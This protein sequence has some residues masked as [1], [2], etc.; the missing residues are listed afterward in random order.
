MLRLQYHTNNTVSVAGIMQ[1]AKR[2]N[3]DKAV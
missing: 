2:P 1:I 3:V